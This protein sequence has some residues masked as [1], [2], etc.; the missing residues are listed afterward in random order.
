[1][2]GRRRSASDREVVGLIVLVLVSCMASPGTAQQVE[3]SAKDDLTGDPA[4]AIQ[5]SGTAAS[6]RGLSVVDADVA[7]AS[8]TAGT[9][10]R[11]TDGGKHWKSV[12]VAAEPTLDFRDIQAFGANVCVVINAGSPGCIFRTEDGGATWRQVYRNE[13]QTIFFD[14]LAFWDTQRGLAVS[15]PQAGH[16]FLLATSDGGKTWEELPSDAAPRADQAEACFAA[17]GTVLVAREEAHVWLATGGDR[18]PQHEPVARVFSSTD[19][20]QTWQA[21]ETPIRAGES[22]GIFSVAFANVDHGVAVG[23]DYRDETNARNNV[24]IT[25]NGGT[26]WRTA[27]GDPPRGYRSCVAIV[28]RQSE[29]GFIAVGPTGCDVSFDWG[30]HWQPLS[31]LGFHTVA[32]AADGTAGWAVGGNGRV[33]KFVGHALLNQ[34]PRSSPSPE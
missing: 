24:A 18:G 5:T 13:S 7:W 11:T 34:F 14:A 10:I 31:D 2:H 19:R 29:R 17:S 1:M 33:A 26:R 25:D 15:D 27:Q 9:V 4:W 12:S 6:L 20:G 21:S 28:Q 3:R 23:G 16:Y 22:A 8:G 32:F 30:N